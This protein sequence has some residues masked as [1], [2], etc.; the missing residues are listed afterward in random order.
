MRVREF[1]LTSKDTIE[2]TATD[3]LTMSRVLY[4]TQFSNWT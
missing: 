2:S 3:Q 4:A 1:T